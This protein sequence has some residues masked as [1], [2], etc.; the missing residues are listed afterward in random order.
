MGVDGENLGPGA[1]QQDLLIAD[2]AEQ[3]LAAELS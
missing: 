1:H 2:M 3:G